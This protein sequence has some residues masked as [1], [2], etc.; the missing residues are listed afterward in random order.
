MDQGLDWEE[1]ASADLNQLD[2]AFV[3]LD[4]SVAATQAPAAS[5]HG[6]GLEG[7]EDEEFA[8]LLAWSTADVAT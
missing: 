3:K 4:V 8:T 2:E 6:D 5:A 1:D 7:A